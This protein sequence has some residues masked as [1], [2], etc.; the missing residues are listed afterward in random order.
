MLVTDIPSANSLVLALFA[1]TFDILAQPSDTVSKNVEYQLTGLLQCLVDECQS[2]P[3][4][5]VDI[6]LAQFLRADPRSMRLGVGKGKKNG[7]HVDNDVLQQSML[8]SKQ[9]PP[10]Y[11]V[12]QSVCNSCVDRMS[13]YV[14][15][16]FSSVIIDASNFAA[17][18]P[19]SKS[20]HGAHEESDD[21]DGGQA[22]S[23]SKDD[24]DQLQKTHLLLRE[25]W[26]ACPGVLHTVIPQVETEL[27]ADNIELRRLATQAFGDMATGIGVEAS[28]Q[29]SVIDPVAY[30]PRNLGSGPSTKDSPDRP[31]APKASLSFAHT[32]ITAYQSFLGR[33]NDK[34]P[35]V[36]AV[37][38]L[39]IG[40]ILSTSAGGLGLGASEEQS[41]INDLSNMLVDGDEKV[42]QAA[43]QALAYLDI[44]DFVSKIGSFQRSS[45]L[46]EKFMD[47]LSQRSREV[48]PV[49][50]SD[51][52]HFI[53]KLW[54]ASAHE[55][56]LGNEEVIELLG[57]IP[58]NILNALYLNRP[59]VTALIDRVMFESLIPL[60]YPTQ[61][62]RDRNA[63]QNGINGDTRELSD[64]DAD[65][66]RVERILLLYK[67]LD[68]R[69]KNALQ[70][71]MSRPALMSNYAKTWLKTCEEYNVSTRPITVMRV[72]NSYL[73]VVSWTRTR[74]RRKRSSAISLGTSLT[75]YP[76]LYVQAMTCGDSPRCMIDDVT[77]S[78]VSAWPRTAITGGYKSPSYESLCVL[79]LDNTNTATERVNETIE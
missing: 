55:I 18:K 24:L 19:A 12:A 10:A 54:G 36:R 52:A 75:S 28:L 22:Q 7:Q 43:I 34:A 65:K 21:E 1:T 6:L 32:H 68:E 48:S 9:L 31:R 45:V 50:R 8:P 13:R 46:T 71:V 51:A 33:R 29:Q 53:G 79:L 67:G 3:S 39:A 2:L 60:G 17:V 58:S 70:S 15:S 77:L 23:P 20:R 57:Q 30:P 5:A 42:R 78:Y 41:L 40:R 73:R 59:D 66:I 37:W 27:S 72:A 25:L 38:T 4:E 44:Q 14:S 16:Y 35:E 63:L 11:N 62:K 76:M 61:R 56:A 74:K 64:Q 26:K 47:R 49:V 69:A